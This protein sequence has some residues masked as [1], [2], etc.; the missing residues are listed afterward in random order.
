[1]L[2]AVIFDLD[3][4]LGNTLPLCIESFRRTVR[5]LDGRELED[6]DITRHFGSSDL[7]VI[8]RLFT[9]C[10]ELVGDA[11]EKMLFHY[12]DLH[13]AM[14]PAPFPKAVK[15]LQDLKNLGQIVAM[16]TGKCMETARI[17]LEKFGMRDVFSMIEPGSPRKV[18]KGECLLRIADHYGLMP[19]EMIY[20]GDTETDIL[21]CREV[22][23]PIIS[24]GW[25]PTTN[26]EKLEEMNPGN[27]KTDFEDF[28]NHMMLLVR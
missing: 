23:V 8:Q 18:I 6:E 3:G 5:D 4:T 1:M 19:E 22:G 15:M 12:E 11:M 9:D 2:R 26:P 16:V 27:V 14:A 13:D 10:P 28:I 17:T 21:A 24:A 7:G 20:V 25:A